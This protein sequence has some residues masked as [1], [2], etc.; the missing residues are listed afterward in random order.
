MKKSVSTTNKALFPSV[1]KFLNKKKMV[2]RTPLPTQS[3]L[4]QASTSRALPTVRTFTE[5]EQSP[6][7]QGIAIQE[8]TDMVTAIR[9]RL[10]AGRKEKFYYLTIPGIMRILEVV[11]NI[12]YS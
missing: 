4:P 6:Q 3:R 1:S 8:N 11:S 12:V 5:P 7:N 10:A 9:N 2:A